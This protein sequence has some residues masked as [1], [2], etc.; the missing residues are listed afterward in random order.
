MTN[1]GL[2]TN[3]TLE[4]L[5]F[6]RDVSYITTILEHY[7]QHYIWGLWEGKLA[8][9]INFSENRKVINEIY[10][11]LVELVNRT[12]IDL[13]RDDEFEINESTGELRLIDKKYKPIEL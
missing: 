4:D 7:E 1:N 9:V 5:Q 6:V 11:E 3:Q 12:G 10:E 8:L 2:K 13:V